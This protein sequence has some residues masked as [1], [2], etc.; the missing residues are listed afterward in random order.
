MR[1]LTRDFAQTLLP[2]SDTLTVYYKIML[3]QG[4]RK[5]GA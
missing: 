2:R 3:E 1:R 5:N 4:V